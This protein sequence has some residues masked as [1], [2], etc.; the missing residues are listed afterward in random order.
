MKRVLIVAEDKLVSNYHRVRLEAMG[1]SVDAARSADAARRAVRGRTPDLTLIDPIMSDFSPTQVVETVREALGEKELWIISQLPA[2]VALAMEKAGA[3]RVLGRRGALEGNLF[4]HVAEALGIPDFDPLKDDAEREAW[5]HSISEAGPETINSL[6]TALHD[7][8]KDTP[9]AIKLYD[10]FRQVHQLSHRVSMLQLRALGRMTTAI[11]AL[12]YDLY[13]TPEQINPAIVRTV[14][15]AIDFLAVLFE[16]EN[17][18]RLQNSASADV[19]VVDDEAPAREVIGAAMKLVHLKI[20]CADDPE[21]ALCV[22]E[23]NQFDLIFLDVNLPRMS[24][25]ELCTEIRQLEDHRHTPI[26]FVTGVNTLLSRAQASLSGGNDFI[27][28]PFNLLELGVKALMW[29]FKGQ[30]NQ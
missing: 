20:I 26:V 2:P 15:Q 11:Q 1:L 14:S 8:V 23:D 28:K 29:I 18:T 13:A 7:F 24:G 12:V 16:E 25:L 19:F 21:M 3:N 9:T 30:I 10:L 5:F 6:R 17:L 4:A 22:L 27:A